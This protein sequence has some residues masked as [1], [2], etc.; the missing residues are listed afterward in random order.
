[1]SAAG[2][3]YALQDL[4]KNIHIPGNPLLPVYAEAPDFQL[5]KMLVHLNF[6]CAL[7]VFFKKI[8]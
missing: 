4:R 5:A 6:F 3:A 1:M 7:E 8:F 2:A